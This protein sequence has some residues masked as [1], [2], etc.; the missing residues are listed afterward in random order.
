MC[1]CA[2]RGCKRRLTVKPDSNINFQTFVQ[3]VWGLTLLPENNIMDTWESLRGELK[4]RKPSAEEIVSSPR[5][6]VIYEA[7]TQFV[8]YLSNT[9]FGKIENGRKK[10]PLMSLSAISK[11]LM[12]KDHLELTTNRS[13]AFNKAFTDNIPARTANFYKIVVAG[14]SSSQF[15]LCSD[16]DQCACLRLELSWFGSL[17]LILVSL[18]RRSIFYISEPMSIGSEIQ[19]ANQVYY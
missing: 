6:G 2:T 8:E 13:K 15:F 12:A 5:K 3:K 17:Q 9:Y 11:Y 10:Q 7:K 19:K 1:C 18:V 4:N 16:R 14:C